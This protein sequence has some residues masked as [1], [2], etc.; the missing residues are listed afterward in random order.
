MRKVMSRERHF[1]RSAIAGLAAAFLVGLIALA[2]AEREMIATCV[3]RLHILDLA[4]ALARWASFGYSAK[5]IVIYLGIGSAFAVFAAAYNWPLTKQDPK[6]HRRIAVAAASIAL[7]LTCIVSVAMFAG[8]LTSLD[9]GDPVVCGVVFLACVLL[10][11]GAALTLFDGGQERS[12]V[13]WG[14]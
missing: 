14:K 13:V 10:A 1:A 12:A 8:G 9:G 6:I 11:G 2:T 7:T 3:A 4:L 5:A